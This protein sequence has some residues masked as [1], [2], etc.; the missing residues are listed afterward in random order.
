MK[1]K[2]N[3][4]VELYEAFIEWLTKP[5]DKD[6]T[7][8]LADAY[9][10]ASTRARNLITTAIE[11]GVEADYVIAWKNTLRTCAKEHRNI[12]RNKL[13]QALDEEHIY[14]CENNTCD[15]DA[16]YKYDLLSWAAHILTGATECPKTTEAYIKFTETF[17]EPG[18]FDAHLEQERKTLLAIDHT[19]CEH[20]GSIVWEPDRYY[21]DSCGNCG[22]KIPAEN[23]DDDEEQ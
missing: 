11:I 20:C 8:H 7:N 15:I 17:M 9:L 21:G 13:E 3:L 18:E 19:R 22:H 1:N 5:L 23:S 6:Y 14:G 12:L 4:D 16:A 10:H 2:N